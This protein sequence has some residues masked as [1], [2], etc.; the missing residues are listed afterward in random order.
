MQLDIATAPKRDSARWAQTTLEWED[1]IGWLDSPARKKECGNYVLGVLRDGKRSKA[2][3]VSRS[4]ITLDADSA[5]P[6]LPEMLDLTFPHAAIVHTTYTSAPDDLR[7]RIIIP[8]DRPLLPD[9]Y[10]EA[11]TVLIKRFGEAQFDPGSV[12]PERY[13]FKPAAQRPEWFQSWVIP[14]EPISAEELLAAFDPDLSKLES[15]KPSRT[16]RDPF[17]IEGIVGA[18]NRAYSIQ[19]AIDAFE[20]PYVSVGAD[21]WSLV[22]SRSVAGLNLI[23]DGLV[24]SHHVTDPVW[25][26]TCSAFDLVRIHRYGDLDEGQSEQTPVNRLKS[27]DAMSEMAST[28]EKVVRELI[29]GDFMEELDEIAD[30][31][32]WRTTLKFDKRGRLIDDIRNWEKIAA[33][34]PAFTKLVFNDMTYTVET[35]GDLPWRNLDPIGTVFSAIDQAALCHYV[36]REYHI[37]PQRYLMDEVVRVVAQKRIVNPLK[38]Y[39]NG[40]VWDG[41][42]RLEE[43]LPGVVPTEYTRMVARKSLVAAV[44]RALNPGCKWDHT[45]VLFGPE[46]LG[47]SYWIERMAKGYW[48]TLGPINNKD[49]YLTMLRSWIMVADEG[50]SLRKADADVQK[51]FLTRTTDVFRLPYDRDTGVHKRH[52]VIWSTTNDEIFLRRQEGNRRFLIVHCEEKVD[53]A[54]LTEEYVDQLWAEA[55]HLYKHGELLFLDEVQSEQAAS[56]REAYTE[57][58]TLTGVILEWL[59]TRVPEDWEDMSPDQRRDWM[60]NRRDGFVPEG[61]KLIAQTCSRQIWVECLGNSYGSAR[62][63]DLVEIASALKRLPGWWSDSKARTRMKDYGPQLVFYRE[64]L[65]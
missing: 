33:H 42:P 2:T 54:A 62:K 25:G 19:E 47:K 28:N 35:T 10:V 27:F 40:L 23:A 3:L 37:R 51:E 20:L 12:Q 13:M 44:G 50:H 17:A 36:E 6:S 9:E 30:E 11:A 8:V 45:L 64:E 60:R 56:H 48:A 29:G 61:T 55:V 39:L 43:C 14:G 32:D 21:R 49:T 46:G 7:L 38:D 15:P 52:C 34:D 1:L 16:K 53:F 31:V 41:K 26:K 57:E 22:G 59:N 63:M 58:D 18:F 5:D 65:I 4:A 24:F